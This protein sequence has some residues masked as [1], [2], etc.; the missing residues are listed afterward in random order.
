MTRL[1]PIL[2]AFMPCRVLRISLKRMDG[3]CRLIRV[4]C[5]ARIPIPKSFAIFHGAGTKRNSFQ[6]GPKQGSFM[7]CR[8]P[9]G[10]MITV[11]S[12]IIRIPT[13]FPLTSNVL[14]PSADIGM[15]GGRRTVPTRMF[16]CLQYMNSSPSHSRRS[17]KFPDD[18][19]GSWGLKFEFSLNFGF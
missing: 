19:V 3:K 17:I 12:R 6:R 4:N 8:T 5:I 11:V 16:I 10:T 18:G 13:A 2:R 7:F 9:A 15:F 1:R 14:S